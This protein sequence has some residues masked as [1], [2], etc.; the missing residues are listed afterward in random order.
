MVVVKITMNFLLHRGKIALVVVVI[1]VREEGIH[2]SSMTSKR[3]QPSSKSARTLFIVEFGLS[4]QT[5]WQDRAFR[6]SKRRRSG[7]VVGADNKN[8]KR[9]VRRQLVQLTASRQTTR[10]SVLVLR[11]EYRLANRA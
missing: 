2:D 9:L 8:K 7:M 10:G 3:L 1:P 5:K 4:P 6:Y 11:V